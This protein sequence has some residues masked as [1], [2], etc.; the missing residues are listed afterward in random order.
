LAISTAGWG[1]GAADGPVGARDRPA[2]A[3]GW[4]VVGAL[5]AR[6]P[7]SNVSVWCGRRSPHGPRVRVAAGLRAR[8][9]AP[10]PR[11]AWETAAN[12]LASVVRG[13]GGRRGP[14]VRGPRRTGAGGPRHAGR[15]E[16]VSPS[17]SGGGA[18][19]RPLSE[20]RRALRHPSSARLGCARFLLLC[21]RAS[22]FPCH[23][24][25][26]GFRCAAATYLHAVL[27]LAPPS[28]SQTL[29][30]NEFNCCH[31]EISIR[32]DKYY[33]AARKLYFFL[34][35][36]ESGGAIRAVVCC[37][38]KL[39]S[40]HA[41]AWG[42]T[43]YSSWGWILDL[44]TLDGLSQQHVKLLVTPRTLQPKVRGCSTL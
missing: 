6:D 34:E 25:L 8:D 12:W 2:C 4:Q 5:S 43:G 7:G 3:L 33:C 38:A 39:S 19:G 14:D 26:P 31:E 36:R 10:T 42:P 40:Q 9:H 18:R 29:Q 30:N 32:T 11:R 24:C 22:A 37:D 16:A 27:L 35:G 41:E 1:G 15:A 17:L 20:G 28:P 21:R 13:R 44:V 23:S